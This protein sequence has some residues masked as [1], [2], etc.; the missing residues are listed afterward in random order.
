[1]MANVV[2][3]A[4]AVSIVQIQWASVSEN[5][6]GVF[7]GHGLRCACKKRRDVKVGWCARNPNFV[8]MRVGIHENLVENPSRLR[9]SWSHCCCRKSKWNPNSMKRSKRMMPEC[10]AS[11]TMFG[12]VSYIV[13]QGGRFTFKNVIPAS[14]YLTW[15]SQSF[16]SAQK[17]MRSIWTLQESVR[18]NE[19]KWTL[20]AK[21]LTLDT[22]SIQHSLTM[23]STIRWQGICQVRPSLPKGWRSLTCGEG[24]RL[25]LI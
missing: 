21:K 12:S 22:I 23:P 14:W 5:S 8:S 10:W 11:D 20:V 15:C 24:A 4:D 16:P 25:F 18:R 6:N 13:I 1:M 17:K 2:G 7:L 9:L 19:V 3:G